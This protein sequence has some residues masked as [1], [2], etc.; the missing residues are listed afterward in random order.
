MLE[1]RER[2]EG[3]LSVFAEEQAGIG[4]GPEINGE[5]VTDSLVVR[6]LGL[7]NELRKNVLYPAAA[8]RLRTSLPQHQIS[9]EVGLPDLGTDHYPVIA[10]G[11]EAESVI[12]FLRMSP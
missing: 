10:P 7:G 4:N 2:L 6:A 12:N 9:A 11:P 1:I 8:K 5:V 3:G